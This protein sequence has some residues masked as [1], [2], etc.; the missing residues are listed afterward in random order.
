MG[1]RGYVPDVVWTLVYRGRPDTYF[2]KSV[3]LRDLMNAKPGTTLWRQ[4]FTART[5]PDG[6]IR[7][8]AMRT[9]DGVVEY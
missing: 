2:T 8:L 7:K 6:G 3:A 1:H 9:E 4:D 5:A